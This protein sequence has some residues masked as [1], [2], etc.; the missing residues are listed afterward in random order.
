MKATQ[1]PQGIAQT[2]QT[3]SQTPAED[4]QNTPRGTADRASQEASPAAVSFTR[5]QKGSQMRQGVGG[6]LSTTPQG[7]RPS[8]QRRQP[9]GHLHT[10]PKSAADPRPA[11]RRSP[12]MTAEAAGAH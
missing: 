7:N 3:P 9:P 5:T 12:P 1:P 8:E 11:D 2:V 4:L 10:A 6:G